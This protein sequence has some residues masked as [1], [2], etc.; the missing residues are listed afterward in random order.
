MENLRIQRSSIK[1]NI[2]EICIALLLFKVFF[3]PALES[4]RVSSGQIMILNFPV[5]YNIQSHFIRYLYIINKLG[6]TETN[7]LDTGLLISQTSHSFSYLLAFEHD[8]FSTRKFLTF[9]LPLVLVEPLF[10]REVFLNFQSLFYLLSQ[11]F[12]FPLQCLSMCL[13]MVV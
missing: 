10:L 6:K 3:F 8:A 2:K 7:T 11:Y 5:T 12:K 4:Y 9:A 13:S 1:A